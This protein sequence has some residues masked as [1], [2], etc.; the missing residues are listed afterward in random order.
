MLSERPRCSFTNQ[1]QTVR[2]RAKTTNACQSTI[3]TNDTQRK[4]LRSRSVNQN[5]LNPLGC[6]KLLRILAA[7]DRQSH[8]STLNSE[9]KKAVS[10]NQ[11]HGAMNTIKGKLI[12]CLLA[13][14]E[15]NI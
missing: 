1:T 7:K 3:E 13:F 11:G 2:I 8:F 5:Y 9:E 4:C 6:S 15:K 14:S 10:E 12:Q